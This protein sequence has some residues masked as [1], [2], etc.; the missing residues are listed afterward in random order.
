MGKRSWHFASDYEFRNFC[1][2]LTVF[3]QG[4][5]SDTMIESIA[6]EVKEVEDEDGEYTRKGVI[7]LR[8][9]YEKKAG[10]NADR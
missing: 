9:M 2:F 8:Q 6:E 1:A 3:I 7:S 4:T 5:V 10:E